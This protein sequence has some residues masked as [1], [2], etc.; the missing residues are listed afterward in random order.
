VL[1]HVLFRYCLNKLYV[2]EVLVIVF[3]KTWVGFSKSLTY[4]YN[5]FTP[6]NNYF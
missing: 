6:L 4:S 5:A 3:Q 2:F 1:K